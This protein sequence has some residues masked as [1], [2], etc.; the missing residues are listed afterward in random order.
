VGEWRHDRNLGG[1][2]LERELV[3]LQDRRRRPAAGPVELGDQ[4]RG[5][6]QADLVDAVLVAVERQHP[7][8]TSITQRLD[9][10]DDEIRR[11]CRV[12]MRAGP[13][14]ADTVAGQDASLK[15]R[16]SGLLAFFA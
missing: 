15:S 2:Q 7:P 4:R 6:V 5:L 3:L 11:Q 9:G 8:V 12:R 16:R 13:A 10:L 14:H 1:G